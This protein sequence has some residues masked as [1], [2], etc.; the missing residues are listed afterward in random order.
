[1]RI[2]LAVASAYNWFLEQLDINNAFLHG[3]LHEDVYMELPP[4]FT[5]SNPHQV[6]KLQ[7]SLC[8]LNQA[9]REWYTN[10][11][12]AMVSLDYVQY[13][14]DHL[15]FIKARGSSFTALLVYVDDIVL[16]RNDIG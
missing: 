10:L 4:G 8:G 13:V 3:D 11:S 5:S 2:F 14:A 12:H 6:C 15:L 7:K 16:A 9:S 1:M